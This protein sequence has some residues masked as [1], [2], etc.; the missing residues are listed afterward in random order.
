MTQSQR[1]PEGKE[2]ELCSGHR[3]EK[4]GV[5][6]TQLVTSWMWRCAGETG[7]PDFRAMVG[8][9]VVP[10]TEVGRNTT[11]AL[12]GRERCGA[13]LTWGHVEVEKPLRT[14]GGASGQNNVLAEVGRHLQTNSGTGKATGVH[15]CGGAEAYGRWSPG[16]H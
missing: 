3:G 12:E 5:E 16:G 2:V 1:N 10:P 7:C 15:E 9:S 4:V 6:W 11:E 14:A 8:C 13:E